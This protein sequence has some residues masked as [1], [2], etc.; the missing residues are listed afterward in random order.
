MV[1]IKTFFYKLF[2][3]I[4]YDIR[5]LYYHIKV[6]SRLALK[7]KGAYIGFPSLINNPA[8]VYLHPYSRLQGYHK[9]I[10]DTGMFIMKEYSGASANLLVVTGNHIPTVGIP[11]FLLAPSHIND[12]EKDVIVEEDVW[13]GANVTLLSG[14]HLGRGTVVGAMSLVNSDIP[15]YA[16]VVGSPAKIIG[17]KFSIQQILAHEKNLYAEDKRFSVDY[18]NEIFE[19]YYSGKKVLGTDTPLTASQE[20]ELEKTKSLLKFD[21]HNR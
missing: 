6:F 12:V 1:E 16:V 17:V 3:T 15:P 8:G 4:D 14:A 18:L 13:I 7:G 5:L 11:Q 20:E 19:K 21:F 10:N 2:D 9:I